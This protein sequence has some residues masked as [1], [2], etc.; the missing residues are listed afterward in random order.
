MT[1]MVTC[2]DCQDH[3]FACVPARLQHSLHTNHAIVVAG[4]GYPHKRIR[5]TARDSGSAERLSFIPWLPALVPNSLPR[6]V[7]GSALRSAPWS[8]FDT[9]AEPS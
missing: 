3:D 4:F 1:V 5:Q 7:F 6:S 8:A 9:A 2:D